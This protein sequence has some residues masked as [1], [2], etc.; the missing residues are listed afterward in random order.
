MLLKLY[1]K[2]LKS[3][4]V[5]EAWCDGD[6]WN[7]R[8]GFSVQHKPP[9][10]P[11]PWFTVKWAID[12]TIDK[13]RRKYPNAKIVITLTDEHHNYREG[14][15]ITKKYKG[16][17]NNPKP[18]YWRQIRDYLEALPNTVVSVNEEADDLMSKA[19]ASGRK[20]VCVSEDKDLK[21]TS[22]LHY[23]DKSGVELWVTVPQANRNFYTQL[24]TGDTVDNIQGCPNVGK[25]KV[26]TLFE[27]I[28][29]IEDY[30]CLVGYQY[31]VAKFK[32]VTIHDP[33]ARMIEMGRLLWMRR[34]DDEMW[35]LKANGFRS[36]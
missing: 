26:G 7:Y 15:A 18:Y 22:G 30:E 29:S 20:V 36:L 28:S 9:D 1:V 16:G 2:P 4:D 12:E 25:T 21:N 27:G 19:L 5:E 23:N 6:I 11:A 13:V 34:S 8:I 35:D 3:K 33:E 31:A 10:P 17:R 24:L 14:I 32:G